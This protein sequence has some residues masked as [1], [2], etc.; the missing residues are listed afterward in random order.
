MSHQLTPLGNKVVL[1]KEEEQ[2]GKS[3][4]G[5]Y[6]PSDPNPH[7]KKFKGVVVAVGPGGFKPDGTHATIDLEPGDTVLYASMMSLDVEVEG[8]PY[9]IVADTEIVAKVKIQD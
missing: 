7:K 4:G 2:L 5:L 1:K 6:L 8:V 3:A 9:V